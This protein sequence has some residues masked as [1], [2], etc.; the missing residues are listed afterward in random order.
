MACHR[1]RGRAAV[2][3]R[4]HRR[5][6]LEPHLPGHRR[7]RPV[8]RPPP[9]SGQPRAPDRPRHEARVHRHQRPRPDRR[10]RPHHLR[11]VH[12]RVG[13]RR[14]VLRDVVRRGPHRAR[15]ARR[16]QAERGQPGPGRRLPHRHPGPAARGGRRRRRARGLRPAGTATSPD[17]SNGGTASSPSRR[18]TASPGRPSSIGCTSCWRPGS[19]NSRGCPSSTATTGWTTPC[20]TTEGEVQAI[21]DWEICTLGD[22]LAD[23]GLLLVYWA[24]PEDGDQA[25]IGVA[26]TALPGFARR[27]DLLA[28]YASASGLDVLADL[29]LPGVRVLEVGLYP[30][31]GPCSLRQR[32]SGRR[33]FGRRSVRRSCRSIGRTGAG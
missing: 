1:G 8:V 21:L 11:A 20:W 31:G 24:E 16:G 5:R 12:R 6:S 19:P 27:S 3:L 30:P 32:G 14:A 17:S 26:P 29:L 13:Q 23:L 10:S 4:T 33:P 28:R 9:S 18:S 7:R 25:L 15:R 22:P 2:H